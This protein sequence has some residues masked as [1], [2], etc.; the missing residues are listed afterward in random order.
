MSDQ[1][2]ALLWCHTDYPVLQEVRALLPQ[3]AEWQIKTFTTPIQTAP[4]QNAQALG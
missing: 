3:T 1:Q 4:V 2:I